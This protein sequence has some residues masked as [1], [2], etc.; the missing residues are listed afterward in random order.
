MDVNSP[1][2]LEKDVDISSSFSKL[3]LLLLLRELSIQA[4][5]TRAAT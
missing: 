4:I 2:I 5:Y 1:T 3:K